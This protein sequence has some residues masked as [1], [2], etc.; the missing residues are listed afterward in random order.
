MKEIGIGRK[1][2]RVKVLGKELE[3]DSE[4]TWGQRKLLNRLWDEYEANNKP[5]DTEDENILAQFLREREESLINIF[6]TIITA[7]CPE[8]EELLDNLT[9]DELRDLYHEVVY[10]VDEEIPKVETKE[11]GN[12]PLA[13]K[14]QKKKAS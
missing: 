13:R 4:M 3:W 1:K 8:A 6:H 12:D 11:E 9:Y 10:P 14:K 2:K 5:P 7:R